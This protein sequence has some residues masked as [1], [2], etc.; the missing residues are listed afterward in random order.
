MT[1]MI[2]VT[3]Y[4]MR[5]MTAFTAQRSNASAVVES[6][7]F[8][9]PSVTCMLCDK[10]KE[11]TAYVLIPHERVMTSILTPRGSDHYIT[12]VLYIL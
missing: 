4:F 1:Y 6:Q 5:L 8:R 3:T 2:F 12:H 10:T 7:F 9:L 11:R